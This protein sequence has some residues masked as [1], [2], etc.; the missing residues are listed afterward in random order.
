MYSILGYGGAPG[1]LGNRTKRLAARYNEMLG[2][3]EGVQK[4]EENLEEQRAARALPELTK[5]QKHNRVLSS[6]DRIEEEVC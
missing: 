2:T 5:A 6:F 3:D 4:L 1:E